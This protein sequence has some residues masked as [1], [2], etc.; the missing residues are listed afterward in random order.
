M[1]KVIS[2]AG[3]WNFKLESE[4]IFNKSITL[5]GSTD[6]AGYGE[7][8][9]VK[10]P[11]RLSRIY[12]Y[13]GATWYQ[14]EIEVNEDYKNKSIILF[15]ERCHWETKVWIDG[16]EIGMNDSLCTA[17]QLDISN[18]MTTGKHILAIRVDNSIKYNVGKDAHSVTMET[19]TNWNGIVGKI[20]LELYDKVRIKEVQV[21][22]DLNNKLAKIFITVENNSNKDIDGELSIKAEAWN[23]EN[24]YEIPSENISFSSSESI[25][26]I[27]VNYSLGENINLWDE[28][29]PSLYK[30]T[31]CLKDKNNFQ[32]CKVIDFGMREFKT[33]GTQF[34]INGRPTFL[35][36]T[37]EC[38]VFPLTGYP[39]TDIVSWL[40]IFET[41]KSYGL[42][43]IRFHSWCPPEAAFCAADITGLMLQIETPVWTV[44]GEDPELDSFI[45]KEGDRILRDYGNHPSFCMLAVGNEPSGENQVEFLSKIVAY[46]KDKDS[47]RLYT[48]TAGWPETGEN[49]YHCLKNR[50]EVL[51]CQDWEAELKGRLNASP[52]T[53]EFDFR[54]GIAGCEVPIVSHEIGQWCAFPN[55]KEIEKYKGIL[56]P[57]N[58]QLVK[59]SLVKNNMV[60]QGEDFLLASGKLQTMLYKADIEAALRTPGFG[61]FQ[62]LGLTDFPGQGTALVGVLDAFWESKGYVSEEEYSR[63]CCETVPLLRME[64]AV[65]KNS[66]TFEASIEIANFGPSPIQHAVI[67]WSASYKDGIIIACEDLKPF[68]IPLGNNIKGIEFKLPLH[69]VIAPA[70]IVITVVIK[71][72][73]YINNWSIWVFKD[74]LNLDT[75][76][77][78]EIAH[79]MKEAFS[80]LEAGKKVLFL[81]K[82]EDLLVNEVGLGFTSI[83]WNTQWTNGQKPHTLGILCDPK[84]SVFNNFIT[85]SHSNWHWFDL[86]KA[87]RPL[88]L[89]AFS[90]ELKPLIQVIDDWN[91][92]RKIGLLFEGKVGTGKLIMCSI[93]LEE[94]MGNRLVAKQ[95]LFSLIKYMESDDFDPQNEIS[96]KQLESISM[97]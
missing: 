47:R 82:H 51:R 7:K 5:P 94:N 21:Y 35:R 67:E 70:E 25:K 95:L 52:F 76:K 28:F 42:N 93:N 60:E 72:T 90:S 55:L 89:N 77:G 14:K 4:E 73:K 6:E 49:N 27:Q 69:T 54:E 96:L 79:S 64:K 37:L 2:L 59:E 11:H 29:S 30:L 46:W 34:T 26:T 39:A 92:N 78:I 17:H 20:Q 38:C 44:L 62:L 9:T 22:P 87:S 91:E 53:T 66:E 10:D 24:I 41:A 13:V 36:G 19:Q 68:T 23:C 31:V 16:I 75:P 61:G 8:N 40:K 81:P 88:V 43:H 3:D 63:F 56:K 58:F 12:K 1:K 33:K 84:E 74:E 80:K 45:Y 15:L 48:G 65:W 18:F 50:K 83:F 32:D 57:R 71:G 85:D 86:I 97:N